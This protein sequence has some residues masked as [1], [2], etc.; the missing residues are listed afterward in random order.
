[1]RWIIVALFLFPA[2]NLFAQPAGSGGYVFGGL[3]VPWQHGVTTGEHRTYLSAPGGWSTGLLLGGGARLTPFLSLE[4]EWRRTGLMEA[5]EPS[6][7]SITYSAQRRDTMIGVGARGHAALSREVTVE[8]SILFELVREQSWLAQR[9]EVFGAPP[10][11]D[12][13]DHSPF[14]NSWGTGF[15]GGVDVRAGGRYLAFLPG[16]RMHRFW[17]GTNTVGTWPGG[18]ADWGVEVTVAA[19]ADF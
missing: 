17:R 2:T 13:T 1:M 14:V 3:L 9:Q 4:A 6:R 16:F 15:A 19:R 7:Y 10:R 12:L 5:I 8:P 11:G 18:R